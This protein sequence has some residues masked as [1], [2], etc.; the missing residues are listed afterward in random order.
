MG[1]GKP[2]TTR[3][4]SA[5]RKGGAPHEARGPDVAVDPTLIAEAVGEAGLSE[6]FVKFVPA[7]RRDKGAN[8]G[9]AG[10]D[11]RGGLSVSGDGNA[12]GSEKCVR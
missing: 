12:D 7:R 11:V 4:P 10:I 2:S 5:S 9:S 6:Q 3:H 1:S 8:F